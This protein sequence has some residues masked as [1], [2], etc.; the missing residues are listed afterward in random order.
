MTTC[1]HSVCTCMHASR[2]HESKMRLASLNVSMMSVLHRQLERMKAAPL[3]CV[4]HLWGHITDS[5][6]KGRA[7]EVAVC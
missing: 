1:L 2:G 7:A 5:A 4:Q 3:P 6:N